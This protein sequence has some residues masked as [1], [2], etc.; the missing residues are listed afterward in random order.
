MKLYSLE[1]RRVLYGHEQGNFEGKV[2]IDE[3]P[4]GVELVLGH[5]QLQP[6]M[7][8]LREALAEQ[9][10]SAAHV[11]LTT[12][13]DTIKVIAESTKLAITQQGDSDHA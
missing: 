9:V 4:G 7:L 10:R 2:R 1:I 11:A 12:I 8:V 5:E 6:I 13:D 3:M